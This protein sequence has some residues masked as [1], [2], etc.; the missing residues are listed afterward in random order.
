M[1]PPG[2][3]GTAVY[4]AWGG[5]KPLC[6]GGFAISIDVGPENVGVEKFGLGR[7]ERFGGGEERPFIPVVTFMLVLREELSG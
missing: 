7:E 3:E 5:C 6:E 4:R 1:N 2:G